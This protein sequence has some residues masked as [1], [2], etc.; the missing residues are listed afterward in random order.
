MNKEE[1]SLLFIDVHLV[2]AHPFVNFTSLRHSTIH[3]TA[4]VSS[5]SLFIEKLFKTILMVMLLKMYVD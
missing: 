3:L 5:R 4:S 1:L 2:V